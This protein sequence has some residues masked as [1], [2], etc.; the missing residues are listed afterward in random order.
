[1][2]LKSLIQMELFSPIGQFIQKLNPDSISAN[3]KKLLQPLVKYMQEKVDEDASINL[4]FICTHNSRRSILGQV[5]A[6]TLAN[7]FQ[8]KQ[9]HS[10]SGGTES[11]AVFP[12]TVN[13]LEET[14][15]KTSTVTAGDNPH[16]TIKFA[17][18]EP[19][20][21]AFSK[22]FDNETNPA[23]KFAAIMTCSQADEDCPFIA[24]AE[25][26]IPVT[27]E[28]PKTFDN[29][30]QQAEKYHNT[31]LQMATELFYVFSQIKS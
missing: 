22:T 8:L 13:T 2:L 29:S 30:P 24:G 14:G 25:T 28:D 31:S 7:Y 15:F 27:F 23:A 6:Q 21:I 26:R 16:Y 3:R 11:T 10:Y 18:N 9:F 4:N 19:A 20:L 1:M 12:M 17:Q 5:W